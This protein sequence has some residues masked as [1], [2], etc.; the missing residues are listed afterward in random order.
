MSAALKAFAAQSDMQLIFTEQDVGSAKTSGVVGTR[1]P[2]EALSQILKG[3]GLEFEFTANNVVVV[4]KASA[5]VLATKSSDPPGDGKEGKSDSSDRFRLDQVDQGKT[6]GNASVDPSNNSVANKPKKGETRPLDEII[7]TGTNIRGTQDPTSSVKTYRREEID[8]SGAASVAQFIQM[9]PQ[10]FSSATEIT[11]GA[12]AN[13]AQIANEVGGAGVDL[14]GLG[15]QSTLVLVNGHRMAPGN[16]HGNFVD[17]SMIPLSAVDRIEILT[18]GGSAIYGS[19]A[20]GG[21]VNIILRDRFKGSETALRY[22]SVTSGIQH[23]FQASQTIGGSWDGGSAMVGYEYLD[24]T[25]L[26]AHSRRYSQDALSP[27]QLVPSQVRNSVFLAADQDIA[28]S[29]KIYT[30]GLFGRRSTT[31]NTSLLDNFLQYQQATV[32]FFNATA[33]IS[34]DVWDDTVVDLSAT[35]SVD[36]AQ[37]QV[38]ETFPLFPQFG[39]YLLEN[40]D[41]RSGML[42]GDLKVSGTLFDL[43]TGGVRYAIGGQYRHENYN[44]RNYAS[45]ENLRIGRKIFAEFFEIRVPLLAASGQSNSRDRLELSVADRNEHYSDFGG[46]NNPKIGLVWR[47]F[48]G[49]AFRSSFGKSFRAPGLNDLNPSLAE[50][51][52]YPMEDPLTGG[53]TNTLIIYGGN[54]GLGPER[55]KTW[56]FGVDLEPVNVPGLKASATYYDIRY[57]DR[58]TDPYSIV[59]NSKNFLL[60]ENL[61]GPEVIQRNPSP[62]LIQYW[63]TAAGPAYFNSIFNIDLST[64][65]A[66]IDA[67]LHNLTSERTR[68]VDMDISY[69]TSVGFGT[70]ETGINA[71]KILTLHQQ[72]TPTS[73]QVEIVDAIYNP[74]DLRIRA[75]GTLEYR[76]FTA[77]LAVNYADSYRDNLT[78]PS[79]AIASWLTEDVALGYTFNTTERWLSNMS[80]SLSVINITDRDPPFAANPNFPVYFDGANANPLGRFVAVG[81]SKKF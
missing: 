27:F 19:D 6:A 34:A 40:D 42:S 59:P 55:A 72:V 49:V 48:D 79:T 14:R 63:V 31:S 56:E 17:I 78:I 81:L 67:R 22:G 76:G 53:T 54:P 37:A 77:S 2:R 69:K 33:G 64:I 68:G 66:L 12:V 38:H 70:I 35:Y 23:N 62:A 24:Q 16:T 58:I 21:V 80:L 25:P 74:I 10:N 9:L 39:L 50:A 73:P 61:V 41:G 65:R 1:S 52:P 3:T 71:T 29:T 60:Q 51:L 11:G 5:A 57:D 13:G 18:D 4:K 36:D 20:V 8:R 47:A 15:P 32:S 46:T 28:Q 26:D 75:H 45:S 7:V 44:N 43:P 30:Q